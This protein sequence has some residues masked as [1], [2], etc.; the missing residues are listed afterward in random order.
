MYNAV[1]Y[2]TSAFAAQPFEVSRATLKTLRIVKIRKPRCV[3][4]TSCSML[5]NVQY[6]EGSRRGLLQVLRNSKYRANTVSRHAAFRHACWPVR[7]LP[8]LRPPHLHVVLSK[9][10]DI[11][12]LRY[13]KA[14]LRSR[15]CATPCVH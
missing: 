9:I 7:K 5:P 14:A 13:A 1:L 8:N 11:A 12:E 4:T 15:R 3:L 10:A 2:Y 6:F